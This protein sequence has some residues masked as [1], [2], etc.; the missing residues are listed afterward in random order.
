MCLVTSKY[1]EVLKTKELPWFYP[2]FPFLSYLIETVFHFL[3][4]AIIF[5]FLFLFI[6]IAIFL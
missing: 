1:L 4:L 3:F 2:V 6:Q 5:P